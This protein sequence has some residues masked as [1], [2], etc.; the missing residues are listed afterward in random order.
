MRA[1]PIYLLIHCL[2]WGALSLGVSP[3]NA[4]PE[5]EHRAGAKGNG[6]MPIDLFA[7][8]RRV[9]AGKPLDSDLDNLRQLISRDQNNAMAHYIMAMSLERQG[10]EQLA[11]DEF[12]RAEK[13][14]PDF[15]D[16]HYR[17]CLLLFRM[18]ET[19]AA[20]D[21][22]KQCE[23]LF[24]DDGEQLFNL[25]LVAESHA[26]R[27]EAQ[28]LFEKAA[29]AK[30]RALGV[31][32]SLARFRISQGR[33]YE[34][35]QALEWD[36]RIDKQNTPALMAKAETFYYLHRRQDSMRLFSIAYRQNPCEQKAAERACESLLSNG[37]TREA[38][39]AAFF[40]LTCSTQSEE[41][42]ESAKDLCLTIL[43][44]VNDRDA[45]SVADEVG[46]VMTQTKYCRFLYFALG[47]IFDRCG[48]K[49][50]AMAEYEQ[51]IKRCTTCKHDEDIVGRGMYRL[52]LDKEE[53]ARDY[54]SALQLYEKAL[55]LRPTDVEIEHHYLRL[56]D[57]LANRNNDFAWKLKDAFTA[58]WRKA[59]DH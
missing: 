30:N 42:T 48:K 39:R 34:A 56:K 47:D 11:A 20:L 31:G 59:D 43:K 50:Q 37:E 16:P 3:L 40:N 55:A 17:R 41:L 13:A 6:A 32:L 27:Q 35:L 33:F 25:G 12:A 10:F 54:Q 4:A 9:E 51:G 23:R 18:Q 21:E 5:P 36:L 58:I 52:A 19:E 24:A 8:K 7:L 14:K 26:Q 15:A 53:F 45:F 1:L 46:S 44:R 57:R 28:R 22:I 38:L 2:I 49:N 29:K